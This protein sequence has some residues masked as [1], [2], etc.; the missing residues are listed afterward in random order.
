MRANHFYTGATTIAESL[1]SL[2]SSSL[3]HSGPLRTRPWVHQWTNLVA[4]AL[5]PL[6]V[7]AGLVTGILRRN[8]LLIVASGAL[9]FSA[10]MS[11]LMH[12]LLD[13]PYPADRTGLYF[14]PLT[15]LTI[16]GLAYG[17]RGHNG[18]ARVAAVAA[19]VVG[20]VLAVHFATEFNTRKFLVW[21]Y[22]ADTRAI[23]DYLVGHRPS[24]QAIVRV[25]GSWQLQESLMFY[26]TLR[27]WTWIEL[28]REQ[29]VAGLDYYALIPQDRVPIE[30]KLGLR[31][32]Y[33]GPVS[34]SALAVTQ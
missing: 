5:A 4:F 15:A 33:R 1:H 13:V 9:A 20:V 25:G 2:A 23:G 18:P 17:W 3:E 31:E 19:Y 29:P 32:V 30:Q 7:A 27:N 8:L 34:G 12:M 6:I 26:A 21:E 28:R 10:V 11:V 16:V 22:D 14:L 24:G